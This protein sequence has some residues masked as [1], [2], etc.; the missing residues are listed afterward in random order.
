[1]ITKNDCLTILV[2]LERGGIETRSHCRVDSCGFCKARLTRGNVFIP[3]GTDSR[4]ISDTSHGII[5]PCVSY[6]MSDLTIQLN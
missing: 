4:R 1:M 3:E 2:A 6:A 5:H